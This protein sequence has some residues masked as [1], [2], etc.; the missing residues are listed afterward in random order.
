MIHD[1][2]YVVVL[3]N[4]SMINVLDPIKSIHKFTFM[5]PLISRPPIGKK[6]DRVAG[7]RKWQEPA[8]QGIRLHAWHPYLGEGDVDVSFN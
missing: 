8:F 4:I 7:H 5:V 6:S 3:S 1:S 2:C